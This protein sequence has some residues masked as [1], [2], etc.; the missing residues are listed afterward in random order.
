MA[1]DHLSV[2]ITSYSLERVFSICGNMLTPRRGQLNPETIS[3]QIM[4]KHDLIQR[5][6]AFL[7]DKYQFFPGFGDPSSNSD[8]EPPADEI[9][10]S[11]E[12]L[13]QSQ[14]STPDNPFQI[15][16]N[17]ED[18]SEDEVD[19]LR[20]T[21]A[22]RDSSS[23]QSAFETMVTV[24]K[25]RSL[26]W[27]KSDAQLMPPPARPATSTGKSCLCPMSMSHVCDPADNEGRDSLLPSAPTRPTAPEPTRPATSTGKSCL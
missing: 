17:A 20:S 18:D 3:Q 16:D 25:R 5:D 14:G 13:E 6:P 9:F 2:F 22:R 4:I 7:G 11:V 26:P 12:N 27:D 15:E 21:L 10:D 1:K 24:P 19:R 8:T 23:S